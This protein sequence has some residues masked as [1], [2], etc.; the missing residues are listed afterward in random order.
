M[1][2][3]DRLA[4][5]LQERTVRRLLSVT[6]FVTALAAF[7]SLLLLLVFFV[8]FER[9]IGWASGHLQARAKLGQRAAVLVVT[10][11]F[12]L[13][14]VGGVVLGASRAVHAVVAARSDFPA[15]LEA[16]RG[17][18]LFRR[19]QAHLPDAETVIASA[20][21]HAADALHVVAALGHT[22]AYATIGLILAVVYRLE[23]A[24]L[25]KFRR[26]L[27]EGSLIGTLVRWFEH[28]ADAVAV[29]VQLQCIVA[30]IN[31]VTTMPVL[32]LLGIS[33]VAPL[34][35]LIFV[36]A[37]VPVIGNLVSGVVLCVLAYQ[38]KGW[39]GVGIFVAL[40]FVLHKVEAYYLNPRLT[41]RHVRLPG[42][43]L[44]VSLLAFEHLLGFAGLFLSFPFLFVAGRIRAEWATEQASPKAHEAAHAG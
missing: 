21:H 11:V 16:M 29:T 26:A 20:Q 42:F 33:H 30:A 4:D 7:K 9:A 31:A 17:S 44:I 18:E 34:M 27:D 38:S 36:S 28:V 24:E 2:T 32:L 3:R 41:A 12:L 14:C 5:F 15:R 19:A 6:L 1:S 22:L 39:M 43:V 8:S 37:L 23:H 10:G 13:L 25:A 35:L 40:T